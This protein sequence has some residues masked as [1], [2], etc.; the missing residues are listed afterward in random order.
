M[1]TITDTIEAQVGALDRYLAT[2]AL[3]TDIWWSIGG[4]VEPGN[5]GG[6]TFM[7]WRDM[8]TW[9]AA[10]PDYNFV[11][12]VGIGPRIDYLREKAAPAHVSSPDLEVIASIIHAA[13]RI[14]TEVRRNL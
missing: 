1:T 5:G 7:V 11:S 3:P 10:F 6:Y 4:R 8:H 14:E 12:A 13:Q 9:Y 2:D